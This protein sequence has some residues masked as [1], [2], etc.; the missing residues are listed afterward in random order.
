ML[1]RVEGDGSSG[2][3]VEG[4]I[5]SARLRVGVESVSAG[6]EIER[7]VARAAGEVDVGSGGA[8]EGVEVQRVIARAALE[9]EVAQRVSRNR[10][11]RKAARWK[12]H[13]HV[14]VI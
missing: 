5:G 7:V 8:G 6:V 14:D 13:E 3:G 4:E 12:V 2:G 10:V 1:R 11:R 9:C